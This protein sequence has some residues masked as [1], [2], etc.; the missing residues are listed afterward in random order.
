MHEASSDARRV[1]LLFLQT[2]LDSLAARLRGADAAA[3]LKHGLHPGRNL[4]AG[5][6][7][8]DASFHIEKYHGKKT[9]LEI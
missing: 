2:H 5:T 9:K 1:K 8:G 3:L 6:I 4:Q 7:T